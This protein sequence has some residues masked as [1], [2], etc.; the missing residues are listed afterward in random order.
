MTKTAAEL[1]P[2]EIQSYRAGLSRKPIWDTP[3]LIARR[4]RAL[5]IASEAAT[6]LKQQF[7]V[8]RVMLF[9]SLAHGHWFT[10]NS[11]IDLVVWGL[12][13]AEFFKALG[14]MENLSR[15][16]EIDLLP[17]ED[18]KPEW[19]DVILHEAELL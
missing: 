8:E 15:G 19:R 14:A 5:Q 18:C 11:D 13:P 4:S 12:K 1:T 6:L 3:E 16:F 9:G 10:R 17:M 7:G 2:E